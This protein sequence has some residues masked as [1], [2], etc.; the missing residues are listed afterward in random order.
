MVPACGPEDPMPKLSETQSILLNAAAQRADGNLL[1]LAGSLRGGAATRVVAAL[2]AHGLAEEQTTE[3]TAKADPALDTVWRNLEDGR[4]VLL[5]ITAAG[6]DALG[7]EADSA[8]DQAADATE[9]TSTARAAAPALARHRPPLRRVRADARG[10]QAGAA[11][12]HARPRR[13]CHD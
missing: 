1:P 2:L 4:G 7:I 12:Y 6:R 13:G 11:R 10:H 8:A 5:R 3:T 9:A